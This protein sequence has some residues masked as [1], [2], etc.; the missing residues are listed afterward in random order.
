MAK[1]EIKNIVRD[2]VRRI[3]KFEN[4]QLLN[5]I[6]EHKSS[7][8]KESEHVSRLEQWVNDLNLK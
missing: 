5:K 4:K 2:E 7:E 8:Q 3:I 1:E 6:Y